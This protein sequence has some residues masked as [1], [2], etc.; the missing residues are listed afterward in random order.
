MKKSITVQITL[1]KRPG[2][3]TININPFN[4]YES[5]NNFF[6]EFAGKAV[7]ITVEDFGNV[8]T[9]VQVPQPSHSQVVKPPPTCKNKICMK[10][11]ECQGHWT[12]E[13]LQDE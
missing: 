7:T 11:G 3:E 8:T 10:F 9:S 12:K 2:Q 1:I 5:M 13:D 6:K 4:R